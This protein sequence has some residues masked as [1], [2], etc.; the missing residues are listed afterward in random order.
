LFWRLAE[1]L[2]GGIRRFSRADED[3]AALMVS[4]NKT[5]PAEAERQPQISAP[6]VSPPVDSQNQSRPLLDA[7]RIPDH[8]TSGDQKVIIMKD[9]KRDK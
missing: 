6:Q 8:S 1:F 9:L 3:L 2:L 7:P 4:Q 5:V